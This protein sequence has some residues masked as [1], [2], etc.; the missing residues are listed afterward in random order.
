MSIALP[1]SAAEKLTIVIMDFQ[2]RDVSQAEAFKTSELIRIEMVKSGS[3]I[4][5]ERAQVDKVLRE[6][7]LQ[8]SECADAACATQVGKIL[9][10][11]KILTGTVMRY[12][13]NLVMAGRVVDVASGVVEFA[14]K[15]RALSKKDELYMVERFC[16]KLTRKITGKSLHN[17][18]RFFVNSKSGDYSSSRMFYHGD[19]TLWL[20]VATGIASVMVYTVGDNY[21]RIKSSRYEKR[22]LTDKLLAGA[23]PS[24]VGWSG[25]YI[26]LAG[27]FMI[28]HAK[29]RIRNKQIEDFKNDIYIT[30][31]TL[32]G[33]ASLM[34]LTFIG[35]SIY[36]AV[37]VKI[38]FNNLDNDVDFFI[39]PRHFSVADWMK[40]KP[41]F[42]LGMSMRF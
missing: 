20:S 41:C 28:D 3:Y 30:S 34:L 23:A 15:E 8:R 31:G 37:N 25:P 4:V 1:L 42:G 17:R 9:S 35:R 16:E 22:E 7:R 2:A 29:T 11:R 38:G 32:G 13:G 5:L 19:P 21:Y 40:G 10:A 18:E 33:F 27:L 26:Q 6:Q 39:P 24:I 12:G 14:E 36:Y